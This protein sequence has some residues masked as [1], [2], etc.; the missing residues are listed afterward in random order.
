[1]PLSLRLFPLLCI[2]LAG[3]PIRAEEM[4][5]REW[6]I[7][8]VHALGGRVG[9]E[10]NDPR[11][12]IVAVHLEHIDPRDTDLEYLKGLAS[13]QDLNLGGCLGITDVGL[14]YLCDMAELHTLNLS[15]TGID[16]SGLKYLQK[17]KKLLRLKLDRNDDLADENLRFLRF[18]PNLE[19]L[20]LRGCH[21]IT[22]N[23]LKHLAGLTKLR[24]LHLPR[25]K[26]TDAGLS[27][28]RRLTEL[29]MLSVGG[30]SISDRGLESL[31]GLNR[32]KCLDLQGC[33]KVSAVGLRHLKVLNQ[34][35]SLVLG[36]GIDDSGLEAVGQL[37]CLEKLDLRMSDFTGPGLKRLR[38]L[39]NLRDLSLSLD[40]GDGDL[41]ILKCFPKL[42]SL[43]LG[44]GM[45]ITDRGLAHLKGLT[46]LEVLHFGLK[47]K[48][49]D[50]G[51]KNLMRMAHL[52]ELDL[53]TANIADEGLNCLHDMTR[54]QSLSFMATDITDAGL[55]NLKSLSELKDLRIGGGRISDK[56]CA[57]LKELTK[58]RELSLFRTGISE[59]GLG[60]VGKLTNLE[61]L[62]L[63]SIPISDRGMQ[64]LRGLRNLK[65]LDLDESKVSAEA[66]EQFK[67]AVP[68]AKVILLV[69]KQS[70]IIP[71]MFEQEKP[72]NGPK[73]D[74]SSVLVSLVRVLAGSDDPGVHRDVLTGMVEAL[75]GRRDVPA[76]K[77]WAALYPKLAASKDAE[78]REKALVL[79]VLFGNPQALAALRKTAGDPKADPDAR[80]RALQTLVEKR[81]DGLLPLL[82]GLLADQTMRGPALRGLAAFDDPGTPALILRHYASF[83]DAEKA[84]AVATLASRP[85]FAL[86]LLDAMEKATVPRRDLSAFTA[87]QLAGLGDAAL[88]ARLNKVWGSIRPPARDRA[89]LLA[90]YRRLVT[91]AALKKANR[92]HG[93]LVFSRTCAN[94]HVLFDAGARIGPDLTGSQRANPEHI[95]TKVLDPNA[96]VARDYLVTQIATADGR[97]LNGLVKEESDKTVTLQMEKEVVRLAK[98]DI[99]RRTRLTISMMPENQL[100]QMSDAE[101]RDLIAYLA[102]PGQVPLPSGSKGRPDP[103]K[104]R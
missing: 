95:L 8:A 24:E 58:L 64:H 29:E 21:E 73:E 100:G 66:V 57:Y 23:G 50:R 86:A 17:L 11:R 68:N 54:L 99:E 103:R 97:V 92:A 85:K 55:Q 53:G 44:R 60:S 93:R 45:K 42:R 83:T 25:E 59:S 30:E 69:L 51:L 75:R 39:K 38:G 32:L 10:E 36:E 37:T 34:L 89:A 31:K 74:A 102:G 63:H 3:S 48:T 35:R 9:F 2:L 6:A 15:S 40:T 62:R 71:G 5:D 98:S 91:P 81:A 72:T 101:V 80:R 28:L 16:G 94:C 27:H 12:A 84:D 26:I 49:T 20:S 87:R 96:V 52:R 18:F 19:V 14:R 79:S 78:V 67:K 90:R 77:G 1:M 4:T 46:R 82:R 22:D 13:L 70:F 47:D 56:G 104:P 61:I 43:D 41:Q 65:T 88:T 7:A 33:S 76:P